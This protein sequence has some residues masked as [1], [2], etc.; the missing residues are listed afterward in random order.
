MSMPSSRRYRHH[1]AHRAVAQPGLDG[2]PFQR[3]IA[4]AITHHYRRRRRRSFAAPGRPVRR[5]TGQQQLHRLAGAGED[6]GLD[7][8]EPK[9]QGRVLGRQDS[10]GP[11][12]QFLVDD[13]RVVRDDVL[14]PLRRTVVRPIHQRTNGRS[15]NPFGVSSGLAMVAEAQM[16]S[17]SLP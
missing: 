16:N 1:A 3:Q 6:D 13:R 17:G 5:A 2:P 7:V 14:A 10:A 8:P 12:P 11:Q 15:I 4:A 9:G